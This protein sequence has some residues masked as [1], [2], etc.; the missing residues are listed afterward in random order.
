MNLTAECGR[1]LKGLPATRG[2]SRPRR[3]TPQTPLHRAYQRDPEAIALWQRETYTVLD[4][5]AK[6]DGAQILFCHESG[7]RADTVRST[8]WGLPD[9]TPILDSPEQCGS[10]SVASAA[11]RDGHRPR[12]RRDSHE[13]KCGR[14]P[15]RGGVPATIVRIASLLY[16]VTECHFPAPARSLGTSRN[17]T[18]AAHARP[19][20]PV[21][22]AGQQPDNC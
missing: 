4:R 12:A 13:E 17:M 20:H 9:K 16:H 2:T 22:Y 5:H 8:T 21:K 18:F 11:C 19:P 10:V 7:F 14:N 3:L 15:S 1:V 6:A